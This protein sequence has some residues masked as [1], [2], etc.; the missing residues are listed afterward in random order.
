MY[1]TVIWLRIHITILYDMKWKMFAIML[2]INCN[3]GKKYYVKWEHKCILQLIFPNLENERGIFYFW[4][5]DLFYVLRR[6]RFVSYHIMRLYT[7]NS[8]FIISYQHKL[9]FLVVWSPVNCKR[10]KALMPCIT[11]WL[12]PCLSVHLLFF[13]LVKSGL[14]A[15]L[16]QTSTSWV[17]WWLILK[18]RQ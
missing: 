11:M 5:D 8:R 18:K 16:R 15:W 17:V 13:L 2:C 9:Q 3:N 4:N 14:L 10:A 6:L 1:W 12:R 7:F